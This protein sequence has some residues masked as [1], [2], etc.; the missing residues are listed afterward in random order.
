MSPGTHIRSN[1]T[2]GDSLLSLCCGIGIELRKLGEGTPITGVDIVPEYIIEFKKMFPWAETHVIDVIKFLEKAPDNSYDVVSCI[3]GIEH[4]PK[5]SGYVLIDES[6]RVCRKKV[7]LFTP[8]GLTKNEP[9]DTWGI[10]GGD[11]YQ[12]HLSGWLKEELLGQG[13]ELIYEQLALS[14]HNESYK[15]G[16]YVYNKPIQ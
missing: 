8:Q 12:L 14:A 3:D 9:K 4:L 5:K 13:F 2:P 6:K 1:L 16:M 15:E 7:L 11:H 10:P